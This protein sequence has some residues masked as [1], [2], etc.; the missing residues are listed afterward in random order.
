MV[1][2]CVGSSGLIAAAAQRSGTVM[3][4]RVGGYAAR[5]LWA[6]RLCCCSQAVGLQLSVGTVPLFT[7]VAPWLM[8]EGVQLVCL[9]TG[10]PDL[11]VGH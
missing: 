1:S 7:Q 4:V 11:E 10:T 9:G 2:K 3:G 8:S 6:L 5:T